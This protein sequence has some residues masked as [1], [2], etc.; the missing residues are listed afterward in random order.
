MLRAVNVILSH[1]MR[2]H[3]FKYNRVTQIK[4]IRCDVTKA[5]ESHKVLAKK[6]KL[7]KP[8]LPYR[9]DRDSSVGIATR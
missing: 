3:W 7:H 5:K 4:A 8:H 9:L 1:V 6:K 2:S